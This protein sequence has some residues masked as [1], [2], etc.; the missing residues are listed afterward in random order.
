[1]REQES[2][3]PRLGVVRREETHNVILPSALSGG[4]R[5]SASS[6]PISRLVPGRIPRASNAKYR[7]L[8]IIVRVFLQPSG[9]RI[10]SQTPRNNFS[11]SNA[12]DSSRP[13][14]ESAIRWL[15]QQG[16]HNSI[17]VIRASD[18]ATMVRSQ[19]GSS[20]GPNTLQQP[21]RK[22]IM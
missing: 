8:H 12:I 21:N 4:P 7:L 16:E 18:D 3:V 9:P 22:T 15:K 6:W 20:K 10:R 17:L 13:R 14:T 5:I 19:R 2:R 1:M 11:N